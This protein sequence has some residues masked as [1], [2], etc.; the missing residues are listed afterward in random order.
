VS[1][2][3]SG[4]GALVATNNLSD[5]ANAATARTNLERPPPS[6]LML[7]V[8]LWGWQPIWRQVPLASPALTEPDGADR[9]AGNQY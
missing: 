5:L 8:M 2:T 4:L 3:A 7:K 9:L 6:I 1:L